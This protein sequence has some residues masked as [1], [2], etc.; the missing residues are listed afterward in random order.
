VSSTDDQLLT[1]RFFVM[2]GFSFTVFLSV[3]QLLPT[4]PYHIKALGGTT[5]QA[6]LFLGLLTYSSAFSAPFTGALADRLGRRRMLFLC[7]LALTGFAIV[8]AVAPSV[9]L[10]LVLVPVHG[11]VWSGLLAASAAHLTSILP[12]SR[13]VEG[14]AYWGMSSVIALALGPPLGFWIL[15]LGW[16][17]L[18]VAAAAMNV[19]MAI[20]ATRLHESGSPSDA[21]DRGGLIEWRVLVL[22]IPLFMYSYSYGGITSFSA[23]LA[24]HLGVTPKSVYLTTLAAVVL[25]T[26][27]VLGR[28]GD[29]FGYRQVFLPCLVCITAGMS[30]LALANGRIGLVTS[31]V[32]FGVGYGTA[33]PVFA[34]YVTH[35]VSEHRRGAAFGAILAAFDTGI[36]TGSIAMGWIIERVGYEPAWAAAAGLALLAL[37]FFVVMERRVLPPKQSLISPISQRQ[38][39]TQISRLRRH[40]SQ[41][42]F[43]DGTDDA[44]IKCIH[45]R[46]ASR[47]PRPDVVQSG[48]QSGGSG[49]G[50]S[51]ARSQRLFPGPLRPD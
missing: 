32:V 43:Q 13:R 4:A 8:Y 22:S 6:G 16:R 37:P 47:L 35:G 14:I 9:R 2:C 26:R 45:L 3:F 19:G 10:L 23:M 46:T 28:F 33:Y 21:H 30:L 18:C 20:I 1:P 15:N 48:R 49:P 39:P 11:I 31:A 12:A 50:K 25:A 36:G 40:K 41:H 44:Q 38:E 24:D 29:R 51:L 5:F 34:A 42:R 17:W 27:P 7:S